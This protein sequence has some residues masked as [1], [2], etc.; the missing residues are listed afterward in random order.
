MECAICLSALKPTDKKAKL[1]CDHIFHYECFFTHAY[2]SVGSVLA[3]C[4]LCRTL[5]TVFPE[6]SENLKEKLM[7]L[8]SCRARCCHATKAG[9][10]CKKKAIPHN[11]GYC[12]LHNPNILPEEL[13]EPFYEYL[14]YIL[15]SANKWR[16]KV[17]M[18]DI[19]KQ[20]CIKHSVKNA[21]DLHIYFLAYFQSIRFQ[22]DYDE[23]D[24]SSHKR[25][26]KELYDAYDL[27][28]P[29]EQWLKKCFIG[30]RVI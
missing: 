17:F 9:T 27:I 25:D 30:R 6:P 28:Y 10:I 3:K 19:V 29:P 22:E 14:K 5:N 11:Y 4:P 21:M 13:Y 23:R 15:I 2:K 24:P 20:L 26:P 8:S 7:N 1:S 18:I 12:K 16:T